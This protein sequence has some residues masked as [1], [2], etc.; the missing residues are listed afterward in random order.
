MSI[1]L[2]GSGALGGLGD[3][4]NF[5]EPMFISSGRVFGMQCQTA[6][7]SVDIGF[8]WREVPLRG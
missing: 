3:N 6:N 7:T 2:T 5:P 4:Y 1:A 8:L